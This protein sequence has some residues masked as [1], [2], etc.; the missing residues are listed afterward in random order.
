[1]PFRWK[2]A[3]AA[4]V[5]AT[6]GWTSGFYGPFVCLP[7]L[8]ADRGWSISLVSSAI[9]AQFLIGAV[10]I[11]LSP[12]WYRAAGAARVTLACVAFAAVALLIWANAQSP[13]QMF[14]AS[15][16]G[17]IGWAGTSGP[18]VNAILTP[19]FK[20]DRHKALSYALN[21]ASVSGLVFVPVWSALISSKGLEFAACVIV[22]AMVLVL[23]PLISLYVA[24]APASSLTASSSPLEASPLSNAGRRTPE[25]SG[26]LQDRRYLWLTTAFTFSLFS[27]M[28]LFAHLVSRMS[29]QVSIELAAYAVSLTALCAIAGRFLLVQV[30]GSRDRCTIAAGNFVLQAIGTSFLAFGT[31]WIMLG[32]GCVIFG[33]GAGN[34]N[35]L[36]PLI[37]Q[38]LF[39]EGEVADVVAKAA[40]INQAIYSLAPVI[41]GMLRDYLGDYTLAFATAAALQLM[42]AFI[43]AGV[44]RKR[45]ARPAESCMSS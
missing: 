3:T 33:A 19:W 27:Q 2:V 9:T 38:Q 41:F 31:D 4:F 18:A 22:G 29:S 28:G 13:W 10:M 35:T 26:L 14:L 1:M 12:D 15:F 44:P 39:R 36:L 8:H 25:R 20:E 45:R 23:G 43:I 6:F 42:A 34:T 37:A 21:G 40:A 24:P 5:I 11:W 32:L 16:L 17:G 30:L 7:V